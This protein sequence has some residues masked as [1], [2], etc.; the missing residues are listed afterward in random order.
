MSNRLAAESSPYLLQHAGNPVDWHPW[1]EEAFARARAEDKPIFLS[2]GYSTCHWCHVMEHESFESA[3]VAAVLN[4]HFVP[5][6]VDRE[7]RP[8]IDRV[9]MLFV[10][11]TTGAGGWP[12]SVWLTPELEPF[13]GGTYFPP[14]GRWGRPGFVDV[15]REI[16][17]AWR[18]ERPR[19][20]ESASSI[21]GR[22]GALGARSA[23]DGEP[24]RLP[25]FEEGAAA[26]EQTFDRRHAGFGDA[27]KFPRPSELLY[28]L[29]VYARTGRQSLATMVG[30][31]LDAMARGGIRDHLGGGFHRYAVDAAWRVPH[32]EK[33]LYD[34]AQLVLA[35]VDMAQV[36]GDDTHAAVAEDTID[37]VLR[38]LTDAGG[39]FFS[40]EDADSVPPEAAGGA[41]PH[42]TEGAF[43]L[44]TVDEVRARLPEFEAE[45]VVQRYGL[46]PDGNAPSDPQGEFTGR[47]ILYVAQ[48]EEAIA[49]RVGREVD[50]V[51]A[52]L[53]RARRTLFECRTGRPRP[54]LD[55]KVLTGWNGLMIA[56]L[57]RAARQAHGRPGDRSSSAVR[58]EEA[59]ERAARFL[60][61]SVWDAD[62]RTLLRRVREGAAA[63]PAFCD[64]Y[65]ALVFGLLELFQ[66]AGRLEWLDWALDLQRR[67]DELF[68][69]E[70]GG[71]WYST[72]GDD[73]SVLLRLKDDYDGAEPSAGSL[74]TLNALVLAQLTGDQAFIDRARHALGRLDPS[75]VRLA[76]G[77][78]LMAS[79][80][81]AL[82][83]GMRQV[84]VVADPADAETAC[85]RQVL[86]RAYLP[87]GVVIWIDPAETDEVRR[88]LPHLGAMTARNGRPTIYV[89][90]DFVCRE[91]V[92]SAD[93]LAPVLE[94][95]TARP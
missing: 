1:G 69:D 5:I 74:A 19:I 48:P 39:G 29:R 72:S 3:A 28:L 20:R 25:P 7:E 83:A 63:I 76:R 88:R 89:C 68:A 62:S 60:R 35:F 55:D 12:M 43:Y 38:D 59:A 10:Q 61:A 49:A 67:Q 84:V 41:R 58:F 16:A 86:A 90:A 75:G 95:V 80:L 50:E 21:V 73:P 71:G 66:V 33:M 30:E 56:A 36:S 22:L 32:F 70:A 40:A 77:M 37:Y 65:A 14:T 78:P 47:N 4:E 2:V 31:T 34:Q 26:F 18:E 53:A 57:A 23:P 8:D 9:Y 79:A 15:L 51:H 81:G 54:G 27:P 13:Y 87:F 11:A 45:V 94:G 17:R 85:I 91:P 64:D 44:W 92:T 46:E 42:K 6:K 24:E 52:A 82:Q 93:A